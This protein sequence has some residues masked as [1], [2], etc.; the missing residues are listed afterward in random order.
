[1]PKNKGNGGKNKRKGKNI[2]ELEIKRELILK[3]DGQEYA[4]IV[5]MLGNGRVELICND[6]K[7]R[8]GIIRGSMKKKIWMSADD[9][10]LVGLRDYEHDKCD[11]IHKY[12]NSEVL[13]MKNR[14][15]FDKC[16]IT[17]KTNFEDEEDGIFL[18]DNSDDEEV[19]DIDNI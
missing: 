4:R 1:M 8:L 16:I 18:N 5:K 6:E 19:L 10:I 3:E 7:K 15:D 17:D 14:G 13:F 2:A 12:N 11:I 9:Y